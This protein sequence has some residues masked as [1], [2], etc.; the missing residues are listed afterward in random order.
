MS[1]QWVIL[2][3]QSGQVV[4]LERFPF[5]IGGGLT[6][7]L[8]LMEPGLPDVAAELQPSGSHLLVQ[9]RGTPL[10]AADGTSHAGTMKL[11]PGSEHGF[12][13][14]GQPLILFSARDTSRIES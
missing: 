10:A 13:L 9:P 3:P 11:A 6:A 8:R 1:L 14:Q 4:P 7:D 12:L 2:D 5:Y